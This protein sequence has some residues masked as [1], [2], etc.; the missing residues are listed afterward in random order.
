MTWRFV[1]PNA[2]GCV[3]DALWLF[4]IFGSSAF[5]HGCET[6]KLLLNLTFIVFLWLSP[7]SLPR[8][9]TWRIVSLANVFNFSFLILVFAELGHNLSFLTLWMYFLGPFWHVLFSF[10]YPRRK[11]LRECLH[12][13][14]DLV[15]S[16]PDSSKVTTLN[17]LQSAKQYIKVNWPCAL[18]LR[19]R[20]LK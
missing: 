14:R 6:W 15:P 18:N 1:I 5:V 12:A 10:F 7:D 20:S 9:L 8:L 2:P 13:L 19:Q 3:S 4:G 16:A 17:L 11:H